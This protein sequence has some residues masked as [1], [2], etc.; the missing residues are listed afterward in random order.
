MTAAH[1]SGTPDGAAAQV[2]ATIAAGLLDEQAADDHDVLK[3]YSSDAEL[4]DDFADSPRNLPPEWIPRLAA[5]DGECTVRERCRTRRL[6][7]T[8]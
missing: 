6:G 1:R 5:T 3:H 8:G 7:S 4:V 2:D